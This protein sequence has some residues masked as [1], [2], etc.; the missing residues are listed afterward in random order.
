MLL[1]ALTHCAHSRR[2]WLTL[3]PD[4]RSNHAQGKEERPATAP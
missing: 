3:T 1:Y 2:D 4:T